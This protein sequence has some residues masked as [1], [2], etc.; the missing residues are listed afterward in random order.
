MDKFLDKYVFPYTDKYIGR[1]KNTEDGLVGYTDVQEKTNMITH[2]GGIFMGVAVIIISILKGSSEMKMIGG[3]I[4]GISL[5]ILY[6]ASSVYHGISNKDVDDKKTFR[7]IDRS[8]IFVLI[9]G[10]CAP[11]ILT[12]IESTSES[13]EW[14]YY[15]A[16]WA[17]AFFGIVLLCVN[18]KKYSSITAVMY[19]ILALML[20]VR[21]DMF[22]KI[23]HKDGIYLLL[24][25]GVVY[26]IGFLF[27]GL[28]SRRK[29]MHSIFHLL[30]LVASALHIVC[31]LMY[32]I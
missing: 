21:A 26:L 24:A 16:I 32:V 14:L 13:L 29:W 3:I 31:V 23:I 20:I 22:F 6:L 5:V 27:Y 19:V 7:I 10:T 2:I 9:A 8:S 12:L 4:F 1:A 25:G 30:C 17:F 28:G 15:A 11:F 18:M